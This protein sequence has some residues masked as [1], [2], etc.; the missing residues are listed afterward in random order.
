MASS[1]QLVGMI[2]SHAAGDDARFLAIAE[3]I[4]EDARKAGRSHMADEIQ[5]LVTNLRSEV[6]SRRP[7][8]PTPI[9]APRGELAGL[10]RASYPE[11]RISDLVLSEALERR[12]W[13]IVR[14]HRERGTLAANGL[15]PRRKLLLSGPPGT[16]KTM[17]AAALA[18][19]LGLPLFTIMLDGVITKY[20]GETAAKLRL[21]FDAAQS[22]RGVYFFDEIDALATQRGVE[23]DIGEA[24]RMLNSLLQFLDE[25]NSSSLL[26][27]ATNHPSLLDQAIF[28]RFDTALAYERPT[29]SEIRRV[30][31]THLERF[32]MTDIDWEVVE[33]T[34]EGLSQADLVAAGRDSARHAILDHDG[35]IN[36][37]TLI[38][39]LKDRAAIT[40]L[41]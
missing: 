11:R 2:R 5:A 22:A 35:R 23:N 33:Q 6:S 39:A 14:E 7:S 8:S 25:D 36:T 3:H 15:H 17:T 26:I 16:G 29:S 10:L 21:I 38:S 24:R 18:G 9:A 40:S 4:A 27:A 20:M 41:I 34:A 37:N 28:R 19:E 12:V 32:K 30:L 13:S 1:K 31:M